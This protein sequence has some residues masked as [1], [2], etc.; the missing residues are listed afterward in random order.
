MSMTTWKRE[1][2]PGFDDFEGRWGLYT[3]KHMDTKTLRQLD[4]LSRLKWRGL[5]PRSLE[6]HGVSAIMIKDAHLDD[7]RT[8]PY[9]ISCTENGHTECRDC[10]IT[11]AT[12]LHCDQTNAND[13]RATTPSPWDTWRDPDRNS[14]PRLMIRVLEQTSIWIKENT[15]RGAKLSDVT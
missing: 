8:C 3:K 7:W 1:Y 4:A 11:K 14:D 15:K 10:P 9:C 5:R 13:W 6:K 2:L 12:G